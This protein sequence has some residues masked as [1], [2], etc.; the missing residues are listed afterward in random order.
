MRK[1]IVS[2]GVSSTEIYH[3]LAVVLMSETLSAAVVEFV[4]SVSVHSDINRSPCPYAKS[5]CL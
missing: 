1:I 2:E 5:L 3:R 4:I